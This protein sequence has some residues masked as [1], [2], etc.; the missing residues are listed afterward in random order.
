MG[1]RYPRPTIKYDP[2]LPD[3]VKQVF[4]DY[5]DNC[6]TKKDKTTESWKELRWNIIQLENAFTG[7]LVKDAWKKLH[8]MSPEKTVLFAKSLLHIHQHM[9]FEPLFTQRQKEESEAFT[10][11]HKQS[12]DLWH[13][14]ND[15]DNQFDDLLAR[16]EF[17]D[18]MQATESF[19]KNSA[20]RYRNFEHD[21]K[22]SAKLKNS[23]TAISRK[24]N[25]DHADAQYFARMMSAS[26]R[27]HFGKPMNKIVVDFMYAVFGW[28]CDE[29]NIKKL[30]H[31]ETSA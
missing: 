11:I 28:E 1:D 25:T 9:T 12:L 3:E 17:F 7:L 20:P 26:L 16:K 5:I 2:W 14:M 15:F 13:S 21:R 6:Y 30:T 4:E 23:I 18:L 24:N 29:E 8:A 22:E 31:N 27:T 10:K 19:I